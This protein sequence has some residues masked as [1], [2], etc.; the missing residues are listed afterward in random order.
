LSVL[1]LLVALQRT[2]FWRP[3]VVFDGRDNPQVAEAQAWWQGRLHLPDRP[4]D[5][6]L[7]D[8]KSYSHFPPLFSLL[9]AAVVP[10]A[11]GFPHAL[12]VVVV[13]LPLFG[14]AYYLFV[15]LTGSV[16]RGLALTF[17]FACGTSV[18]PV[19]DRV[20]RDGSPWF[21]NSALAT[22][23][24]LI[25]LADYLGPKRLWPGALGLVVA[26]LSRQFTIVYFAALAAA[27]WQRSPTEGRGRKSVVLAASFGLV[28]GTYA[29]LNT[30]K[31]GNPLDSGYMR[32]YDDSRNDTLA[33]DAR[34][35]GVFSLHYV[36]R[37]LYYA[38]IG[39]P[40][41]LG[42]RGGLQPNPMGTGIWWTT[43]LLLWVFVDAIRLWRDG[44]SRWL[45]VC[46]GVVFACLM[47]YHSTGY[48]QR[49]YNRYSL[50]YLPVLLAL[51]APRCFE[52]R[53]RWIS[54]AMIAW[55]VGY[56][57]WIT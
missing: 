27:A 18:W 36:P 45:L 15:R 38:N 37:N 11:R 5:S 25:F 23:G 57:L 49:G 34:S 55:G 46:A 56:F 50:D 14:A 24:L 29:L 12:L 42:E 28:A 33:R 53:R 1:L 47:C 7:V 17:A 20:L 40:R 13:V 48:A 54:A 8:G 9:S 30:I 26:G 32:I 2:R 41:P 22:L 21:V 19:I 39:L 44:P 4:Y 51:V 16:P 31:F 6:A 35:H 52:G 43:P 3:G 10:F